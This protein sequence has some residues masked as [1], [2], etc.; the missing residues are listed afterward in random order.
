MAFELGANWKIKLDGT[1]IAFGRNATIQ[2]TNDMA[3]T[4]NK[5]SASQM[6][7]FIPAYGSVTANWAGPADTANA[8]QQAAEDAAY[9]KTAVTLLFDANSNTYSV[10]GYLTQWQIS[11]PH[12]DVPELTWAFQGTGAVTRT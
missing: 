5:D 7:E 6:K 4:T 9:N 11:A 8:T 12:D 2:I 3:E 10:S 1:T